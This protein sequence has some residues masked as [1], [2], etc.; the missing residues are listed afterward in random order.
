MQWFWLLIGCL[1]LL[2][3]SLVLASGTGHHATGHQRLF[4]LL[5]VWTVLAFDVSLLGPWEFARLTEGLARTLLLG[6]ENIL[7]LMKDL[8]T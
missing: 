2:L 6:L 5:I 7:Q 3:G 1:I 8:V 4:A